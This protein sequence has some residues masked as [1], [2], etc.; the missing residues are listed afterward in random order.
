MGE[1]GMV[2]DEPQRARPTA[3]GGVPVVTKAP[4]AVARVRAPPTARRT[5]RLHMPHTA[6][7]LVRD[8]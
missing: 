2:G 1:V 4:T 6:P 7:N 3:A 8:G 5:R